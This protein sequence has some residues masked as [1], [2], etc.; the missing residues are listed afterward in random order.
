MAKFFILLSLLVARPVV[1][2]EGL[3]VKD[4]LA[5]PGVKLL[6]VEFYASWRGPCKQA[7]PKWKALHEKY[8]DLG[9]RLVVVSVQDPDGA[10]VNPGWNPDDVICDTEGHLSEAWGVG[11]KLPA[12]FLWSWRGPLLVRKGHVAEVNR[13]VEDELGSLPRVTL[14]P[15]MDSGLR[16]LLRAELARTGKVLVVASAEEESA[17]AEIRERSRDLQFSEKSACKL[18]QRLAA[19]SLLKTSF[20]KAGGGKKLLVQLFSA[21]TGCLNASAGVFWNDTRPDLSAAEAVAELTNELRVAV[22]LPGGA[23][24]TALQEREI[25]EQEESWTMER[26]GGVIV[27]FQSEPAGAVVLLDGK[28]LCQ[29]SPCSKL[30]TSGSHR[31]EFQLES[32]LPVRESIAVSERTASVDRK[33]TPD[34]GWSTVNSTPPGLG[35]TLDGRPWGS[36]PVVRRQVSSGPHQVLVSDPSHYDKGR[37]V[38]VERGEHEEIDVVLAERQGG[39]QV[40]AR[41]QKE[42]DLRAK[43]YVDGQEVGITPFSGKVI[44]GERKVRVMHDGDSWETSLT[45]VEKQVEKVEAVLD[46]ARGSDAETSSDPWSLLYEAPKDPEEEVTSLES[47]L[48]GSTPSA[49]EDGRTER[50]LKG[51]CGSYWQVF[52]LPF[53]TGRFSRFTA[54]VE[55]AGEE[56]PVNLDV[57]DTFPLP[58][59]RLHFEWVHWTLRLRIAALGPG[60]FSTDPEPIA[61]K[62]I[63]DYSPGGFW[64]LQLLDPDVQVGWRPWGGAPWLFD[65]QGR[66]HWTLDM[67][68]SDYGEHEDY[69][70]TLLELSPR[71]T[72]EAW[73][74]Y[75]NGSSRLELS[76]G[77]LWW[78][79]AGSSQCLDQDGGY[80]DD[81]KPYKFSTSGWQFGGQFDLMLWTDSLP[82]KF[83]GGFYSDFG[84]GLTAL[85]SI[86]WVGWGGAF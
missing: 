11:D 61:G 36:T 38:I 84:A 26:A 10:C 65:L 62:G 50:S 64:V 9:L 58:D 77:A 40:L 43:V 79:A 76:A 67:G 45:V 52:P 42:N 60:F 17:L 34:F 59:L 8:R 32:Y 75:E 39:I 57:L 44:V 27:A 69:H 20:V 48:A 30:V 22:E 1:A 19:N 82:F 81:S 12:A 66:F 29:A 15:E 86:H 31:L 78:H 18:G 28:V 2:G 6:A 7:V 24:N 23:R 49:W 71:V 55:R 83:E 13:A 74:H 46:V 63:D 25:G 4:W 70:L 73:P 33:L 14:D 51:R 37:E 21:E 16:A 53:V 56:L 80:C 54:T 35:I 85:A 47:N 3:D 72:W 68:G 5:R 41:D